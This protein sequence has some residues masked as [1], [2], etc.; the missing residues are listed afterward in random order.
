VFSPKTL[1]KTLLKTQKY[2][3]TKQG[4]MESWREKTIW[5]NMKP[6]WY[7]NIW[8][9]NKVCRL[10]KFLYVIMQAPTR[11]Q[12]I[13]SPVDLCWFSANK[14]DKCVYYHY[15]V[16]RGLGACGYMFM[17]Y[18]FRGLN[19][20]GVGWEWDDLTTEIVTEHEIWIPQWHIDK[21]MKLICEGKDLSRF[22]PL[23]N[24]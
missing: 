9:T 14:Q 11:K 1:H 5:D 7:N 19:C 20:H 17:I 12:L 18:L 2:T 4:L 24:G 21:H 15:C 6:L 8:H 3:G 23:D 16:C 13:W 10:L 22:E